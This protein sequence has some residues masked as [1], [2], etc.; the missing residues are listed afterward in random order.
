[1]RNDEKFRNLGG[2]LR[3]LVAIIA[4]L[5]RWDTLSLW[6]F[7]CVVLKTTSKGCMAWKGVRNYTI[8]LLHGSIILCFSQELR[9]FRGTER[10][11]RLC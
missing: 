9:M 4:A 6:R 5:H 7:R 3:R 1:M 11:Q 10:T 2:Q 8:S